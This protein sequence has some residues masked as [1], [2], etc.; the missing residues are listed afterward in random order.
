[1]EAFGIPGTNTVIYAETW[2]TPT[3]TVRLNKTESPHI[4]YV[5][6]ET[7][8]WVPPVNFEDI[9]VAVREI[10]KKEILNKWP[11]DKQLEAITDFMAGNETKFKQ[12]QS[13]FIE[14]KTALPFSTSVTPTASKT[15]VKQIKKK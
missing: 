11:V 10:R 13:D 4:G 5:I 12:L 8:N 6:D 15:K 1:M 9:N 14:I 3:G 7:G 2:N